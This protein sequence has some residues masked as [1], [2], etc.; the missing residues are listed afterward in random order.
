MAV[1][2]QQQIPAG[3]AG[4]AAPAA[5]GMNEEGG[6]ELTKEAWDEK[7]TADITSK[8]IFLIATHGAY[9]TAKLNSD[10][11]PVP[12]GCMVIELTPLAD[13]LSTKC[14]T[15]G[16]PL[17]T[18]LTYP[19]E[20]AELITSPPGRDFRFDDITL[21]HNS[22]KY[23]DN[24]RYYERILLLS[25]ADITE[26][27]KANFYIDKFYRD[28]DGTI[29]IQTLRPLMESM[30]TITREKK[31]IYSNQLINHFMENDTHAKAAHGCV[32][33]LATCADLMKDAPLNTT[34]Y[35]KLQKH[36]ADHQFKYSVPTRFLFTP[37]SGFTRRKNTGLVVFERA[38][39]VATI[40]PEEHFLLTN[41]NSRNKLIY[42]KALPGKN[43]YTG[44][45]IHNL[46]TK[47]VGNTE[48]NHSSKSKPVYPPSNTLPKIFKSIK[49]I[50]TNIEHTELMVN[51]KIY[52]IGT[53]HRTSLSREEIVEELRKFRLM[54]RSRKRETQRKAPRKVEIFY[55][56]KWIPFKI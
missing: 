8:P 15:I 56:G 45:T 30:A 7:V 51:N 16:S 36:F 23:T 17:R 41:N 21:L 14:G 4:A 40:K 6:K 25:D 37:L 35:Y 52:F 5:S 53:K 13:L 54:K 2:G 39:T 48:T 22:A 20:T 43:K 49:N 19:N 34:T 32:C 33:I 31:F 47:L 46:A 50:P 28:E 3:G 27:Q 29:K 11:S 18:L 55:K 24:D 1:P 10:P 44:E 42:G 26:K 9:D 38:P 12:K